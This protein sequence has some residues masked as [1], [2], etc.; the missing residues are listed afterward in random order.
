MVMI[1]K[2]FPEH[3]AIVF[4]V[5]PSAYSEHDLSTLSDIVPRRVTVRQTRFRRQ[6]TWHSVTVQD[7]RVI[8]SYVTMLSDHPVWAW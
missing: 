4:S 2:Y 3:N 1:I 8:V 6:F 5:P 7:Y